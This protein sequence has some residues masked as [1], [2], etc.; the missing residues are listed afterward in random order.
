MAKQLNGSNTRLYVKGA[1]CGFRRSR[2]RQNVNQALVKIQHVN[3]K[4]DVRF[5]LGKR[6]AYVYKAKAAKEGEAYRA[7]WGKVCR[8]HGDNGMVITKFKNNLPPR[9]MGATLRVMLYPQRA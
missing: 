5:Y 6:V 1:F 9:A 4:D 2:L 7:I 8:A 3:S